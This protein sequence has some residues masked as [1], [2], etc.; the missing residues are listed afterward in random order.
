MSSLFSFSS[1]FFSHLSLSLSSFLPSLSLSLSHLHRLADHRPGLRVLHHDDLLRLGHARDHQGAQAREHPRV[2]AARV[3]VSRSASRACRRE[4]RG[5]AA[6][7]SS[8]PPE[9][10]GAAGRG[11]VR[12][13]RCRGRSGVDPGNEV[14]P[15]VQTDLEDLLVGHERHRRQQVEHRQQRSPVW[16][17]RLR[18]CLQS[19]QVRPQE[20][21]EEQGEVL[22]KVLVL[23]RPRRV[24]GAEAPGVVDGFSGVDERQR[25]RS[26][27]SSSCSL[28]LA[29]RGHGLGREHGRELRDKHRRQRD[30]GRVPL[31]AHA[32]GR[33]LCEAFQA[34]VPEGRD[35][36][37][38]EEGG[39]D[40]GL[41]D[42]AEGDLRQSGWGVG[43]RFF[44]KKKER[45][46]VFC[47]RRKKKK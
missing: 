46:K 34:G 31:R 43:F 24:G 20:R 25:R 14:V 2:E 11:R 10:A 18:V 32:E 39:D 9:P 22:D 42:V 21:G 45:K 26:V 4:R 38:A 12:H 7:A 6:K 16:P 17:P 15:I 30:E 36:E 41:E 33:D 1:L 37:E 29:L 19:P 13:R 3:D 44:E 40:V 5:R 27:C 47:R 28:R 23:V 8:G 35:R